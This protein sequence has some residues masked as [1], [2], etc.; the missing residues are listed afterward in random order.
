MRSP[1]KASIAIPLLAAALATGAPAGAHAAVVAATVR[2][3]AAPTTTIYY[4]PETRA[5]FE[6]QLRGHEIREAEFNKVAEH[7]HLLLNDGH[8][9]YVAYPGHEQPVLQARLLAAGVPVL[10]ERP[11]T[12]ASTHH[13]IRYVVAGV[14][15]ILLIA[16][17][18]LLI[19]RRRR[20]SGL[21]PGEG[22]GAPAE[23]GQ[24]GGAAA[25]GAVGGPETE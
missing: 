23:A 4:E 18:V 14:L 2:T 12:P 13:T 5:A 24:A 3:V 22:S 25:G 15:V 1:R 9:V 19:L 6:G 11:V 7:I 20:L 17:G 16:L 10:I 21:D 8:R